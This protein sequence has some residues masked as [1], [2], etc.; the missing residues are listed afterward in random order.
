MAAILKIYFSLLLLN[1]K[2]S[3]RNLVGSMRVTFISKIAQIVLIGN[4]KWRPSWKSILNF[5]SWTKRAIDWKFIGSIEVTCPSTVAKIVLIGNLRQLP[6]CLL[7]S[8]A[9]VLFIC[10]KSR[11]FS[12]HFPPNF[13]LILLLKGLILCSNDHVPWTVMSIYSSSKLRTA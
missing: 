1:Q 13:T 11:F 9:T 7:Y 8:P 12:N 10:I 2:A 4:P 5:F 6:S 3:S